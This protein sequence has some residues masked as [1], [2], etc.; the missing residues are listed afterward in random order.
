M[1]FTPKKFM[2]KLPKLEYGI[3]DLFQP[4]PHF[5]MLNFSNLNEITH[6]WIFRILDQ[7]PIKNHL[8][9]HALD[10]QTKIRGSINGLEIRKCCGVMWNI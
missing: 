1:S 4:K 7:T 9:W 3:Y 5:G 6:F 10:R 2:G 8:T